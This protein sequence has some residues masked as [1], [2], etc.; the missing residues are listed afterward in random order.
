MTVVAKISSGT[1]TAPSSPALEEPSLVS[2]TKFVTIT[3]NLQD[4]GTKKVQA[5]LFLKNPNFLRFNTVY[6]RDN[7]TDFFQRYFPEGFSFV[8][9]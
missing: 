3:S 1:I 7:L 8:I 6:T 9:S 5:S 4:W 2:A